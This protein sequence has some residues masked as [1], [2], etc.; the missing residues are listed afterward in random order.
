M[1][2]GEHVFDPKK[3]QKLESPM[4]R[5]RMNPLLMAKAMNLSGEEIVLDLG[6][7]TGFFAEEIAKKCERLIGVDHSGDMLNIFH[8]KESFS[9]LKNVELKIGKADEIPVDDN[10]CDVVVHICLFHE[11]K[12]IEKFHSEIKRVLKPDGKLFCV[13]WQ[14]WE[15]DSGPPVDHRVSKEK[16]RRLMERDGFTAI[17]EL[18]VYEDQYVIEGAC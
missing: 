2:G 14:A 10:S 7:G 15:T 5:E 6:C 4:R 1:A 12:D 3:W 11:I 18:F 8:N 13:D 9:S 17:K 16:V